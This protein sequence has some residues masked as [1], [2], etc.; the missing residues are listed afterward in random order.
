M[1]KSVKVNN[2]RKN[3]V[4]YSLLWFGQES[5]MTNYQCIKPKIEKLSLSVCFTAINPEFEFLRNVGN[6]QFFTIGV[7]FDKNI[8]NFIENAV[9]P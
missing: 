6:R 3:C 2:I 8:E 5:Q 1:G 7:V 9:F 4:S